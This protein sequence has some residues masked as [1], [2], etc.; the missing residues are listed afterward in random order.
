L[1]EGVPDEA[2]E[3][4]AEGLRVGWGLLHVGEQL[5]FLVLNCLLAHIQLLELLMGH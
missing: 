4:P 3:A 1:A 5:L 2:E